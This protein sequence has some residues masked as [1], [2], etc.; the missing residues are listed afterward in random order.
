MDVVCPRRRAVICDRVEVC[1][2]AL[3]AAGTPGVGPVGLLPADVAVSSTSSD[4]VVSDGRLEV[5]G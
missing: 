5:R 1:V 4:R 3:A 2:G